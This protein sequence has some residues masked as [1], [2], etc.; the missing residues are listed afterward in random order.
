MTR[1]RLVMQKGC[2]LERTTSA[3]GHQ[4][5]TQHTLLESPVPLPVP[6]GFVNT[7]PPR[8]EERNLFEVGDRDGKMDNDTQGKV[9]GDNQIDSFQTVMAMART[10]AAK[11]SGKGQQAQAPN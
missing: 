1:I 7:F 5:P 9:D 6:K 3:A 8:I 2:S 11:G 10:G 4:P